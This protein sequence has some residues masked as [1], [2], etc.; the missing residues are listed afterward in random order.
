MNM[1]SHRNR[2]QR[3]RRELMENKPANCRRP[4]RKIKK[5]IN[6]LDHE[7]QGKTQVIVKRIL[8]KYG[9]PPDM[10]M[11]ATETVLKQA[12]MIAEELTRG[13]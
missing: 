13:R 10:Q 4:L 7:R 6:R 5:R 9:Y 3:Q 2:Q 8:R 12:E 11:L 1:P